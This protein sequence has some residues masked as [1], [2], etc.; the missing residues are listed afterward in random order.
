M[1]SL[2]A[3]RISP[4][5]SNVLDNFGRARFCAES[6]DSLIVRIPEKSYGS[7]EMISPDGGILTVKHVVEGREDEVFVSPL[8]LNPPNWIK[9]QVIQIANDTDLALLLI[10]ELKGDKEFSTTKIASNPSFAGE[11]VYTIGFGSLLSDGQVIGYS[12]QNDLLPF[13][14]I[15][16]SNGHYVMVTNHVREADS[17]SKLV[18]SAAE[19]VGV[20]IESFLKQIKMDFNGLSVEEQEKIMDEVGTRVVNEIFGDKVNSTGIVLKRPLR[21]IAGVIS[22]ERII[23]FLSSC[24]ISEHDFLDGKPIR[25]SLK[26]C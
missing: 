20:T 19:M 5:F 14:D 12:N 18:N 1:P 13:P 7:A 26:K 10:P 11:D 4:D 9:A 21:N 3:Q 8:L 2:A 15:F 16:H 24:G 25:S 23:Q 6:R 17:G 22:V